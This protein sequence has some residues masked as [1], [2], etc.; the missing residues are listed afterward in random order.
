MS[1]GR[2]ISWA[3][4][5]WTW[6]ELRRIRRERGPYF[7]WFLRRYGVAG[8]LALEIATREEPPDVTEESCPIAIT[9]AAARAARG[10]P[11]ASWP[12]A[13]CP[14]VEIAGPCTGWTAQGRENLI[15]AYRKVR[16]SDGL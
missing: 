8:A 1:R 12:C 4:R 10:L 6:N 2:R 9:C 11:V 3:E 16:R 15:V 7:R 5:P 13:G 14:C